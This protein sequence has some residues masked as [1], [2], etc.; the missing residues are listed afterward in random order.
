MSGSGG[1]GGTG[2]SGGMSGSG[3]SG[4]TGGTGGDP[5]LTFRQA[6]LTNFESYPDPNSDECIK[7]NGCM[8]EGQ[9]AFVSGKQ[10]VEWVM[11]HN[12]IAVHSKDAQTYKL[13]TCRMRQ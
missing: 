12:I 10:T 3:G 2:G 5:G 6:N 13:K 9:F 7:F 11:M 8:W 4:G 1:A